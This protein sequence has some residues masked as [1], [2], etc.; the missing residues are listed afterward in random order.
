MEKLG[1]DL[2]SVVRQY[3]LV[4][5]KTMTGYLIVALVSYFYLQSYFVNQP[6]T[7]QVIAEE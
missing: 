6:Q 5:K 4:K 2:Y 1:V 7:N 3:R